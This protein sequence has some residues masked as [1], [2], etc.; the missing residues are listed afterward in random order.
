MKVYIYTCMGILCYIKIN[1]IK[2]SKQNPRNTKPR[3]INDST[4]KLP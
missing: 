1:S 4:V 2:D 3:N